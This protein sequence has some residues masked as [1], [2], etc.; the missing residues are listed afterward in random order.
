[1][2][3]RVA[4]LNISLIGLIG[5]NIFEVLS[6]KFRNP[7]H[8]KRGVD[9]SRLDSHFQ[10]LVDVSSVLIDSSRSGP[11]GCDKS[12]SGVK[13]ALEDD[14]LDVLSA[15]SGPLVFSDIGKPGDK[16]HQSADFLRAGLP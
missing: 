3:V 12:V 4:G 10:A 11:F 5:E 13:L 8:S 6:E 7:S 15:Q 9:V 2:A 14:H 1:M 16:P